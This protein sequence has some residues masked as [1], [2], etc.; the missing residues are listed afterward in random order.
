MEGALDRGKQQ[1]ISWPSFTGRGKKIGFVEG[2]RGEVII[3]IYSVRRIVHDRRGALS[4][5][6]TPR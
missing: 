3:Y 6:L 1:K 4:G 5:E 2:L